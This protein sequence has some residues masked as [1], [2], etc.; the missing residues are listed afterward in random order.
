LHAL[1]LG[2]GLVQ[3]SNPLQAAGERL[4]NLFKLVT[5]VLAGLHVGVDRFRELFADVVVRGQLINHVL[6][7]HVLADVLHDGTNMDFDT[8]GAEDFVG[9]HVRALE[10][11]R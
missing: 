4:V 8:K 6:F 5:A 10:Y 3:P 1:G 7:V 9:D 2:C 11:R